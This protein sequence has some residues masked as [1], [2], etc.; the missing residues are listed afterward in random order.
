MKVW[1]T[2]SNT[3]W[4]SKVF[5]VSKE[6][7]TMSSLTGIADKQLRIKQIPFDDSWL[8]VVI[9]KSHNLYM[10]CPSEK[11]FDKSHNV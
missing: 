6:L 9:R 11:H 4:N 3:E 1:N 5:Q 10:M 7:H 2:S 8:C